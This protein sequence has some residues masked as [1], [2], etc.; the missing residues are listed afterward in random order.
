MGGYRLYLQ[1]AG[2]GRPT[3][4]LDD[5]FYLDSWDP[6]ARTMA[7]YTRTCTYDREG[8][9]L[10]DSVPGRISSAR[11]VRDV[12]RV[13]HNGH[14]P[15]P[16]VLVGKAFGGITMRLYS[17]QHNNE[18]AA[19]VVIDALPPRLL[20]RALFPSA[21]IDIPASQAQLRRAAALGTMPLIVVSHQAGHCPLTGIEGP[22]Q[23]FQRSLL[24]LS[25]RTIHIE[26]VHSGCD[27]LGNQ[28]ELVAEVVKQVTILVRRHED[29]LPACG[30]A[31]Q[32][33][34][35]RCLSP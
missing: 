19:L 10:S 31:L 21:D 28:P 22:W 6:V 29:A 4:F 12:Y 14:I 20:R 27:V 25:T 2:Q 24:G 16:Y 35:G 30:A 17:S 32:V 11:L 3:I 1:C 15:G 23:R 18:V 33:F 34:H 7:T 9:G 5:A 13:L 26:A 8:L